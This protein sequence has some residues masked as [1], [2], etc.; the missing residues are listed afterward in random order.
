[1]SFIETL[2]YI[3]EESNM[4]I[5]STIKH[6]HSKIF[7]DSARVLKDNIIKNMH[8]ITQ[9][10]AFKSFSYGF[11]DYLK[12]LPDYIHNCWFSDV[13]INY[14]KIKAIESAKDFLIINAS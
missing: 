14:K 10:K 9:R 8:D 12:K 2:F 6:A 11:Y 13:F 3:S 4:Q 1:M 7:I 5:S